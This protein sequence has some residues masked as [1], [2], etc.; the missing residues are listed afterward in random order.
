MKFRFEKFI[1]FVVAFFD[2]IVILLNDDQIAHARF[3]ISLDSNS[4]SLCDIDKNTNR[5]E[6][7][8]QTKFIFWDETLMQRKWNMMIV[9]RIHIWFA[10][11]FWKFFIRWQNDLLLWKF[12]TNFARMLK[13]KKRRYCW[14]VLAKNLVLIK[15]WNFAF[16]HQHETSKF[17]SQRERKTWCKSICSKDARYKQWNH[18]VSFWKRWQKESIMRSW[19]HWS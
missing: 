2:I 3:K 12:Q 6:F 9:N 10:R 18:Y 5:V 1:V 17:S 19:I 14:F 4:Q 11:C 8:K 15:D 13:Q 16:N 7:I